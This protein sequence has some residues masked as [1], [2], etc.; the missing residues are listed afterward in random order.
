M[1]RS[2]G[3][4]EQYLDS[5]PPDRRE[6]ISPVRDVVNRALP[7]GYV[8]GIAFGMIGWG[9]PLE[10]FPDTYNGQPL[11]YVALA[12]QKRYCSLYLNAVYTGSVEEVE[13]RRRWEATG[14]KLDMGKS[15]V[16]FKELDDLDLDLVAAVVGSTSVDEF[17]Q[18]YEQM[19]HS[20][21]AVA[22]D[23]GQPRRR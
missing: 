12:A 13:F 6:V 14:R 3:T 15:C 23:R 21:T 19:R 9:V 1:G 18:Q 16:R 8:E 5:L 7:D 11:S 4:V 10:R 20:R 2:A 22:G 17:I